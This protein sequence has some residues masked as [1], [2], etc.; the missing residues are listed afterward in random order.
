MS[1]A[2]PELLPGGFVSAVVRVGDTVRRPVSPSGGFVRDLLEFFGRCR[3]PGAPRHLGFDEQGREVLTFLAGHVAWEEAQPAEVRS[4]ESLVAVARLVRQ[5]HDLTAGTDLA[6]DQDV[7]CHNDLSPKNTVYRDL[8][9][10]LRPVA[11]IDWDLA[12]PGSRVQDVAHACWQYVGLGP[13]MD[14]GEAARLVR[15]L[16]D[17]YGPLAREELIRTVLWWQD[18]CWRGIAAGAAA[19]DPA[20]M[21]LRALGAVDGVRA[22]HQWTADHRLT[23]ERAVS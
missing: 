10:G 3:W 19:G 9:L 6:G 20:M 1:G 8:G 14:V 17:A 23:L 7:V 5:L 22:A 16:A 18:R 21:R 4:D 15:L 13:G 2:E 12:A 11:F